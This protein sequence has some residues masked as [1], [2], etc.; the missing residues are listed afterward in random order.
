MN[1]ASSMA[2][3]S[4][5]EEALLSSQESRG[6]GV[7][8]GKRIAS[9]PQHPFTPAPPL[10][11]AF[12]LIEL[13]LAIVIFAL[14]LAAVNAVFFGAMKLRQKTADSAFKALPVELTLATLRRDLAGIV[15]PGGTFAGVL[16][17]AATIQGLNEQNV[18]TEIF[19]T[20]GVFRD[21][22][23]WADIQRVAYVLRDPTN[24]LA[25]VGRDLVRV[26]RR[27]LLP[28]AEEHAEEQRL[29]SDVSRIDF[30][31]YDGSSWRTSWNSTNEATTLPKAIKVE[32]TVE[33]EADPQ[34]QRRT[35][36][37]AL[38]PIQ[39]VV[40]IMVA[41]VTNNTGTAEE[42]GGVQ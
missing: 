39:M 17:S 19:T 7:Q 23:P 21:P 9:S 35:Q 41:S 18:G 40:P 26:V 8:G 33:P 34:N 42:D 2:G 38:T 15:M 4:R 1:L 36:R 20:S 22:Q 27:N 3:S 28:L 5:R 24:R 31:F 30:S 25:S 12:T 16:D 32:I 13:L 10:L 14:I 29:M 11:R 6:E 37:L